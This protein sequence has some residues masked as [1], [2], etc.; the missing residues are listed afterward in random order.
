VE[1]CVLAGCPVGGT[2]LDP[3]TGSGTTGVVACRLG[4]DFIG[5]ELNPDYAA[6]AGRR[7]RPWANQMTLAVGV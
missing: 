2:V 6:M 3:F 5:I 7:I 4:R 1:P